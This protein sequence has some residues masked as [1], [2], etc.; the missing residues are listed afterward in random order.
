MIQQSISIHRTILQGTTYMYIDI[1]MD[2]VYL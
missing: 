2:I 1:N